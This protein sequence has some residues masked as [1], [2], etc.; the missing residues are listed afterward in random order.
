MIDSKSART[1]M[2]DGKSCGSQP[3]LGKVRIPATV[4]LLVF[5]PVEGLVA[6]L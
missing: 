6:S 5:L 1:M 2:R 4:L 3:V